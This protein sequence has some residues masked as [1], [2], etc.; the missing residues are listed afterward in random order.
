MWPGDDWLGPQGS[1]NPGWWGV[2]NM[3]TGAVE[4]HPRGADRVPAITS[5]ICGG[6]GLERQRRGP[7][8]LSQA[9][10]RPGISHGSL[11]FLIRQQFGEILS[12]E[13]WEGKFGFQYLCQ[14]RKTG[15]QHSSAL[16]QEGVGARTRGTAMAKFIY[17]PH[18]TPNFQ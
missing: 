14:G 13:G 18:S 5:G 15:S 4:T 7:V 16:G 3:I 11:V 8:N 12:Q 1:R 17:S 2:G 10:E 9:V 6:P